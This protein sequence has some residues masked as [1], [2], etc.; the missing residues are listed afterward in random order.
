MDGTSGGNGGTVPGDAP[1]THGGHRRGTVE[2]G[3]VAQSA[4]PGDSPSAL[5]QVQSP[6][7][8][9]QLRRGVQEAR[10]RGAQARSVRADDATRRTG[11]RPTSGTT[12]PSSSA[13]PGT[14]PAPI[15][16]LTA[17]A[18]PPPGHAALRPAQQLARQRNLD[19][20]RRLLWPIKQK[21]GNKISWADLMVLAGN[22]AL[23]SMGFKTFGFGGGRADVWEPEED[24]YWGAEAEWLGDK[25]YSGDRNWRIRSR[26]CRWGSST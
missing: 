14:A 12:A 3:L 15:A 22:C 16:R 26:P 25:R 6:R 19:K 24:V 1:R 21:Y 10:P 13:W 8:H 5:R 18:A 17:A 7:R 11:G 23:E 2:P 20:A 9:V 4:Q